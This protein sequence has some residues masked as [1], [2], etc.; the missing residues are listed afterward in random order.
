MENADAE[1]RFVASA[2]D[3]DGDDDRIAQ[4]L[5]AA[6]QENKIS[7]HPENSGEQTKICVSA[8]DEKRA[9]E[10]AREIVE[11]SPPE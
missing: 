4:F 5:T 9:R 1:S 7:I 2:G 8:A 11:G 3:A 10:I 6:M